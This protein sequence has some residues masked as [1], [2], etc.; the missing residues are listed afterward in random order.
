MSQNKF[1]RVGGNPN[2]PK[3][4]EKCS[5]DPSCPRHVHL[6]KT[7]KK[8]ANSFDAI[9]NAEVEKDIIEY[10]NAHPPT[11]AEKNRHENGVTV[12]TIFPMVTVAVASGGGAVYI[13]NAIN[14]GPIYVGLA[15]GLATMFGVMGGLFGAVSGYYTNRAA[16]RNNKAKS[17]AKQYEQETGTRLSKDEIKIF[18]E[19]VSL[20]IT[21]E[22]HH[23]NQMNAMAEQAEANRKFLEEYRSA[24]KK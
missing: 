19:N 4:W 11:L 7:V 23:Q 21:D 2:E 15:F 22:D 18:K 1:L 13:A 8:S 17:L 9:I 20:L 14:G 10:V 3:D 24:S 16:A 12:A 6:Q 5:G